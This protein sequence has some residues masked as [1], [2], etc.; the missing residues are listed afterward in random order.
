MQVKLDARIESLIDTARFARETRGA[1]GLTPQTKGSLLAA[2]ST[3]GDSS[4]IGD[5]VAAMARAR[6]ADR[7]SDVVACEEA[8]AEVRRA[9]GL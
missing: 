9:I 4:W 1:F 3:R 5:A 2:E 7:T 6:V 8:L